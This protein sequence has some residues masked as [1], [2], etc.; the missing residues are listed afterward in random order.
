MLE[1]THPANEPENLRNTI[2]LLLVYFC[3]GKGILEASEKVLNFAVF[4]N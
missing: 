2:F 4:F 3:L 1:D